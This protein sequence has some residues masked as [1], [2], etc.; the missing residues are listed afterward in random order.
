VGAP[1][2]GDALTRFDTRVTRQQNRIHADAGTASLG[3]LMKLYSSKENIVRD[4]NRFGLF[5][6]F[7][8]FSP[9]T[10]NELS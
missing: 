8:K 7:N 3:R 6:I 10:K 9:P 2:L 4:V 1:H 5:E